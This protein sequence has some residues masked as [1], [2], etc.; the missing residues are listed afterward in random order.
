LRPDPPPP[1]IVGGFGPKMADLAGRVAD[2]VNLPGGSGLARLLSQAR[3]AR[4]S[5][6]RDPASFVVT[7]SS[8]L[9][10]ASLD[11]LSELQVDRVVTFISAP[12]AARARQLAAR[13][14]NRGA[15]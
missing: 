10:A 6:G 1:I 3:S 5:A 9:G 15:R 7:V 13:G 2:G 14:Q 12:L 4:L 8:D 11:R